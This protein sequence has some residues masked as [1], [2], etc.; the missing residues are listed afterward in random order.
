MPLVH[1]L[2]R[3]P[4]EA[5]LN[6]VPNDIALLLPG[7]SGVLGRSIIEDLLEE[8]DLFVEA[9]QLAIELGVGD[10]GR[11]L[12]LQTGKDEFM[13]CQVHGVGRVFWVVEVSFG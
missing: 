7:H 2:Y 9:R 3:L 6:L 12:V 10:F 8:R 11:L 5:S 4:L 1:A 13:P